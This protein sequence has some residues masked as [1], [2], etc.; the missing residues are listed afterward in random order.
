M[1]E[2]RKREA[3]VKERF[4]FYKERKVMLTEEDL[5]YITPYLGSMNISKDIKFYIRKSRLRLELLE[6]RKFFSVAGII[7]VLS[8]L[9]ILAGW[10][11]S[12]AITERNNARIL[13]WVASA[14]LM[15]DSENLKAAR[16][17]EKAY[18][19]TL[20]SPSGRAQIL[21]SDIIF[22]QVASATQEGKPLSFTFQQPQLKEALFSPD[23]KCILAISYNDTAQLWNTSGQILATLE[24]H[25]GNITGFFSQD[26]A[27]LLSTSDDGLSQLWDKEGN[28]LATLEGHKA[29]IKKVAFSPNGENL[30]TVGKDS[31]AIYWKTN[32]TKLREFKHENSTIYSADL[33]EDNNSIITT[34]HDRTIKAWNTKG[35]EEWNWDYPNKDTTLNIVIEPTFS[36]DS[37]YVMLDASDGV[38]RIFSRAGK[39]MFVIPHKQDAGYPPCAKFSPSGK[40]IVTAHEFSPNIL[41]WRVDGN[42]QYEIR[43]P[44]PMQTQDEQAADTLQHYFTSY[45]IAPNGESIVAT[46]D[47]YMVGLWKLRTGE[48]KKILRHNKVQSVDISPSGEYFLTA[49]ANYTVKIWDT[50]GNLHMALQHPGAGKLYAKFS[51][52]GNYAITSVK[53]EAKLWLLHPA[54]ISQINIPQKPTR[55]ATWFPQKQQIVSIHND[56][57]RIWDLN[58]NPIGSIPHAKHYFSTF[59][60]KESQILSLPTKQGTFNLVTEPQDNNELSDSTFAIIRDF[61]GDTIRQFPYKTSSIPIQSAEFSPDGKYIFIAYDSGLTKLLDNKGK[62]L[63]SEQADSLRTRPC[64]SADSKYLVVPSNKSD[65]LKVYNMK[66][67]I[68]GRLQTSPN[69]QFLSAVFAPEGNTIL[70]ASSDSTAQLWEADGKHIRTFRGHKDVIYAAIFAPDGESLLTKSADGSL[71]LWK[72][73]GSIKQRIETPVNPYKI[74]Q[75]VNRLAIS[76]DN[77]YMLAIAADNTIR[78]WDQTGHT[79]ALFNKHSRKV[80]AAKFS[81][82]N[83]QVLSMSSDGTVKIWPTPKRIFEW[84][85]SAT[86]PMLRLEDIE[87]FAME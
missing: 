81:I 43:P 74:T 34:A 13:A 76:S 78:I 46:T 67:E 4:E 70:T 32:G 61:K 23:G 37:Q 38:S 62:L 19:Q 79:V 48:L 9:L 49:S 1:I 45:A 10:Q 15:M 8:I 55:Y 71:I 69:H 39:L 6:R 41:V 30:L 11:W 21:L 80:Y 17:L 27:Y 64:F 36:P 3:Y 35:E 7:A 12:S 84:L 40:Y 86:I 24:G 50:Q 59:N 54:L 44:K 56:S 77:Q 2:R 22:D 14:Q 58:H 75:E 5:D 73:N 53:G 87:K 68:V 16:L 20:P 51:P 25:Q 26:G 31:S 72:L 42:L 57:I 66:G 63:F 85:E 18:E 29:A 83:N 65:V 33:S 82:D 60:A 47:Q 52:E 28:K